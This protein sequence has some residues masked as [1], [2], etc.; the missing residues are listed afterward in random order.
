MFLKS[1]ETLPLNLFQPFSQA[2]AR[3]PK[4]IAWRSNMKITSKVSSFQKI[5]KQHRRYNI[6]QNWGLFHAY[7]Y[8]APEQHTSINIG[9]GRNGTQLNNNLYKKAISSLKQQLCILPIFL[10]KQWLNCSTEEN[11]IHTVGEWHW[12]VTNFF[13]FLKFFMFTLLSRI[14]PFVLSILAVLPITKLVGAKE[15]NFHLT[16]SIQVFTKCEFKPPSSCK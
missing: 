7:A 15:D 11:P 3:Y 13:F 12:T 10:P 5:F 6:P 16:S 14:F 8:V 2:L 4:I 9:L 1:W